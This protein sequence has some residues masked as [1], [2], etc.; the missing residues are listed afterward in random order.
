MLKNKTYEEYRKWLEYWMSK[1]PQYDPTVD[2]AIK[3][4]MA[5]IDSP[6]YSR[7]RLPQPVKTINPIQKRTAN[8]MDLP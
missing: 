5:R 4:R 8:R 3:G 1:L 7:V 6:R 2:S